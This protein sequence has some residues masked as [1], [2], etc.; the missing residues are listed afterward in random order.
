[1]RGSAIVI[2][3]ARLK[4]LY[5]YWL[6]KKRDRKA[7]RRA[8]IL[9]EEIA[10]I[11]PWVF[12][13]ERVG[14]RLRYRLVGDEFRQIYGA[15][16]IGMFMDE[17]DLDHVTAAYIGEYTRAEQE[18]PVVRKWKFTKNDGRHVEYERII[19]PLSS[20]G[21]TVDMFLGGAVG[22]GYG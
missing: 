1:L 7:P 2:D 20:D 13:M 3:D 6:S 12:L 14:H 5:D 8:D 22:F 17:V 10:D 11:L 19:L 9:P 15:K 21:T 16:L 18:G 4:R